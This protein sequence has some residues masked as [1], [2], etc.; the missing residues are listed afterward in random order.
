MDDLTEYLAD[1][2]GR[3]VRCPCMCLKNNCWV[4]RGCPHWQPAWAKDWNE[5]AVIQRRQYFP[6]VE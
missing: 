1:H 6:E 5:L 3:C 4:G 2:Y